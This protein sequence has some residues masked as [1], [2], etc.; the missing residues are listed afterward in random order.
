MFPERFLF[1]TRRC[2]QREFLL[3]PDDETNNAF[4]YLLAEAAQRFGIDVVLIRPGFIRTEFADT[5]NSASEPVIANAGP[6]A[7]YFEG[8]R[9]NYRRWLS[10]AGGPDDI[11]RLVEKALAA[12]RPAPRYAGPAH[13][14]L[15]LFIKW[16]LPA[17]AIDWIVRLRRV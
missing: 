7:P 11:A 2:T 9:G 5:A 6:Y 14:K 17:R 13:A 1:I 16:L 4:T 10:W 15:L 3:R 8:F 12:R